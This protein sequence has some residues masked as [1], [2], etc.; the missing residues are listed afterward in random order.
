[1]NIKQY[2]SQRLMYFILIIILLTMVFLGFK[3]YGVIDLILDTE[4]FKF[5]LLSIGF[6]GALLV[7]ALMA[8]AVLFKFLPSAAVALAAGAVYGHTWGTIYIIIGA[9]AGAIIAFLITRLLGNNILCQLSGYRIL[10]NEEKSQS[11]L[12]WGLLV[13]RFIPAIP[14]DLVSYAM[15]LTPLKLWRFSLATLIGVIPTSF[16]LAHVGGELAHTSFDEMLSGMMTAGLVLLLPFLL[17]MYLFYR[18]GKFKNLFS[19]SRC[20]RY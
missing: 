11:W 15:G 20:K 9:W 10:V 3:S 13:S 4:R 7:I 14:Y 8:F 6:W 17:I 5:Y 12:M 19:V 1:M 18:F 2:F 16:F